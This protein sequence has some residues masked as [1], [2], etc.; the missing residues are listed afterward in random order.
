MQNEFKSKR[1]P[2]AIK[3]YRRA[4]KFAPSKEKKAIIYSNL[5]LTYATMNNGPSAL[6]EADACLKLDAT[7]PKA[8]FRRGQALVV[9]RRIPE[10][11]KAFE[12]AAKLD[13][14]SK[15]YAKGVR[16]S[17]KRLDEY[18]PDLEPEKKP[19]KKAP[20]TTSSVV[21]SKPPPKLPA[22]SKT[23][24]KPAPK[25]AAPKGSEEM[26]GY[27]I[28]NGKKT[29]YFHHEMTEEEK[30]LIGDITPQRIDPNQ[31]AAAVAPKV[32][33]GMS[34]WNS[35]GTFE[36]RDILPWAKQK[37]PE[38]LVDQSV[39]CGSCNIRVTAVKDVAG[40]CSIAFI[41]QRKRF[42]FELSATIEWVAS[43]VSPAAKL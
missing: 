22:A 41:K 18:V 4:L 15:L 9:L 2:C 13:P 36:D 34:E 20:T 37:L 40:L 8:H 29:S 17:Q 24:E 12:E 6:S 10:S 32:A 3:L 33:E 25:K 38:L 19:E 16:L 11:H 30:R 43:G 39:P 26:R 31:Q 14:S 7:N 1:L 28:V 27:K 5:S 23:S 42:L 35:K 21:A